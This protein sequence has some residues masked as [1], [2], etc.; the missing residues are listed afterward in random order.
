M[1]LL[2]ITRS[3]YPSVGGLEKFVNDRL[4]IY[5]A[6]GIDYQLISTTFT[7]KKKDYHRKNDDVIFVKEYTPYNYTPKLKNFLSKD[8]DVVSINQI[9]RYFSDKAI[10]YYSKIGK[11]IILTPHFTFHTS[12]FKLIKQVHNYL[13]T[14]KLLEK[15]TKIICFTEF[16][17]DYWIN[18]Y[19]LPEERV[20]VIPHYYEIIET[21]Q[22]HNYTDEKYLF[23]LGRADKNKRLDFL[24][25]SFNSIKREEYGLK[26]T[27]SLDDLSYKIK[28]IVLADNRIELLG[29]ISE[30]EKNKYLNDCSAMVY[31]SDFEAFGH[32]LLEGANDKK[33]I[34]C[35]NLQ[36]FNEI[37][38]PRGVLYFENTIENIT[39]TLLNFYNIKDDLK[40]QM[41][42]FNFNNLHQYSYS[43]IL[44]KYKKLFDEILFQSKNDS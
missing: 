25:T 24:I 12:K 19:N 30:S 5:K 42:L 31:P 44:E 8:Y 7:N 43:I 26:L 10:L 33:P 34:I 14:K 18:N 28:K 15:C 2:E 20:V 40:K 13:L 23:Y 6:L 16:E 9:G 22:L 32:S 11:K 39:N 21:N 35:S 36:V 41:G 4:K 37:L 27:I 29:N 17:K 38:D 1:K 3:F